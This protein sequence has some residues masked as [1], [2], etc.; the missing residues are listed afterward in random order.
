MKVEITK[1]GGY[2]CAPRGA[3]VEHFPKGEIVTGQVAEWALADKAG[4][5][6]KPEKPAKTKAAPKQE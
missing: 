4:T 1:E 5:E 2:N 3:V 6:V